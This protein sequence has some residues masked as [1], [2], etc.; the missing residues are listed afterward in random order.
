[1]P[2]PPQALT[3]A[4][5]GAHRAHLT[6]QGAPLPCRSAERPHAP[7][8]RHLAR[9]RYSPPSA[10]AR[11]AHPARGAAS[12]YSYRTSPPRDVGMRFNYL[13]HLAGALQQQ[14]HQQLLHA[15][16][17]L[18]MLPPRAARALGAHGSGHPSIMRS[19]VCDMAGGT[20]AA[21]AAAGTA[22]VHL[23]SPPP[24]AHQQPVPALRILAPRSASGGVE[25]PR[26]LVPDARLRLRGQRLAAHLSLPLHRMLHTDVSP[27]LTMPDRRD[28]GGSTEAARRGPLLLL[29][30]G[31]RGAVQQVSRSLG[32]GASE[33]G[34][35]AVS[36]GSAD[37]SWHPYKK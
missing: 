37:T 11:G 17:V 8:A 25:H 32:V 12:P 31:R 6:A 14:Q 26:P 15:R 4:S 34:L 5:A 33:L 24:R 7:R 9:R 23:P 28:R 30:Q 3:P 21:A 2:G 29:T 18:C 13:T 10:D 16:F 22:R 27:H 19:Q 35:G 36:L 20:A 1:M